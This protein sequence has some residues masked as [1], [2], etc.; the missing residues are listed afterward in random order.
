MENGVIIKALSGF[1]YVASKGEIISCKAVGKFKSRKITPLVGDRIEFERQSD[2]TGFIKTI[3]ERKNCFIRPPLANIDLLIIVAS[4]APPVTDTLLIDKMTVLAEASDCEAIICVNKTDLESAEK[5]TEIYS[6][7]GYEVYPVSAETGDGLD[8]LKIAMQS[9]VCAFTGNSGVGKSSLLNKLIP[10]A[11]AETGIISDKIGRGKNTT[12]HT[13]LFLLND[14]TFIADTAGFS[15]L[16]LGEATSIKKEE[17][18]SFYPEFNKFLGQC[19]FPDCR[20]V[21]EPGCAV[22]EAAG[23]E[24]SAE[25]YSNYLKIYDSVKSITDWS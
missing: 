12:R 21:S 23:S 2:G 14:N 22:K 15:S 19:R 8:E 4:C 9:R 20:H 5:I 1:Y 25:R 6:K 16:E 24:I 10:D 18:S 3:L 13:E 7:A 11:G 17:L